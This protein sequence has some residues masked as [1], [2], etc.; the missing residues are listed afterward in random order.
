MKPAQMTVAGLL[1]AV[2]VGSLLWWSWGMP[3][4]DND[5][6]RA[7]S[8][9]KGKQ[10]VGEP[11]ASQAQPIIEAAL[12]DR[13]SPDPVASPSDNEPAEVVGTEAS[14]PEP[15]AIETPGQVLIRRLAAEIGGNTIRSLLSNAASNGLTRAELFDLVL[16]YLIERFGE[17]LT[18]QYVQLYLSK[19][20]GYD[21][22][23]LTETGLLATGVLLKSEL[24]SKESIVAIAALHTAQANGSMSVKAP[25]PHFQERPESDFVRRVVP[26]ESARE[27]RTRLLEHYRHTTQL[28]SSRELLPNLPGS[29]VRL[30]LE[31]SSN[32]AEAID[33]L[34][35]LE[36]MSVRPQEQHSLDRS[37]GQEL[38][39]FHARF[40]DE[41]ERDSASRKRVV[42]LG[43]RSLQRL[44]YE[45]VPFTTS[46]VMLEATQV[47][48][49]YRIVSIAMDSPDGTL[50]Q[51]LVETVKATIEKYTGWLDKLSEKQRQSYRQYTLLH[52]KL[53][54]WVGEE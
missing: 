2:A 26:L 47:A 33:T 38:A 11:D 29:I 41:L 4:P 36:Q 32:L 24:G 49:A 31:S 5:R 3:D 54:E 20:L 46:R 15:V 53:R 16:P 21:Q 28:V 39:K 12:A 8:A 17:R 52:Q 44:I 14:T 18:G 43:L 7:P 10:I 25:P 6:S 19:V 34:E 50:G 30:A 27:V 23:A 45:E 35:Q 51:T 1:V 37:H 42:E 13:D 40:L 48:L 22:E 9:P